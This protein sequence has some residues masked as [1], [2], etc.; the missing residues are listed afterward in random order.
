MSQVV[1][2]L[3]GAFKNIIENEMWKRI[4]RSEKEALADFQLIIVI[5]F[6]SFFILL[7]DPDGV[8]NDDIVLG[9]KN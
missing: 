6:K 9:V 7:I 1:W 2:V 5:I 8:V 4:S 3:R